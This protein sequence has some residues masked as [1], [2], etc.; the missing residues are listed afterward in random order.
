MVFDANAVRCRM[1]ELVCPTC[2]KTVCFADLKEIPYRP[3]CSRRCQLIDLGKWLNEE[4]CI[5]EPLDGVEEIPPE[6]QSGR[7]P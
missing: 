6:E 1:P 4:Y 7:K 2:R 3:F 5:S